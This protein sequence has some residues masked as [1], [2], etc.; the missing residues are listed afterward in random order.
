M[1]S[2]SSVSTLVELP[3][4]PHSDELNLDVLPAIYVL[5]TH[6]TQSGLH[7]VEERL[8]ARHAPLTYD[9]AEATIFIG[10]IG[11]KRRAEYELRCRKLWTEEVTNH[12][13][14]NLLAID[15]E[16]HSQKH[17]RK[18]RRIEVIEGYGNAESTA[19]SG[20]LPSEG[21]STES[22]PETEPAGA[23]SPAANPSQTSQVQVSSNKVAHASQLAGKAETSITEELAGAVHVIRLDWLNASLE[24][25]SLLPLKPYLVYSGK[26]V[27]RPENA[28][29]LE[30]NTSFSSAPSARFGTPQE[31][32]NILERAKADSG[33]TNTKYGK[34]MYSYTTTPHE[35]S[36][37]R[38]QTDSQPLTRPT[39]LLQETTSEHDRAVS[40]EGP[41][42]PAW[43]KEGKKYACQRS[44]R[45]NPPNKDFIKQLEKIKLARLLTHDQIGVRAYSTSIA[46]L[47]A[48]PY[49]LSNPREILALPGCDAKIAHLYQEWYH[50]EGHIKVVQEIED[51]PKL[52]VLRLFYEIWGVGATTARL[53]YNKGWRDLDDIVEHGW[54]TLSRVQQIG[55]KYYDQFLEKIP[56]KEV[57][58][59]SRK[60]VEHAR[61]IRDDGIECCI[62]GGY[63]R[64]KKESGDVDMIIS[65][66][67][68]SQTAGLITD[69][70]YSLEKEGWISHTL[71]L[72]LTTSNRGQ[73]TLPYRTSGDG[74]GFDSLD[75]ALVVWQD[76]D[77]PTKMEDLAANPKAKNPNIH[78]RV[79]I[80]ISPWRTVGCAI[81]GWSGGTIF[82]RDLRRYAK[83]VKGWKF[84]SSGIRDR[85]SGEVVDVEGVGGRSAT[86]EEAEKKVF[87]GLGLEY[88]EPWERC[89]G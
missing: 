63:R 36:Q 28:Q 24:L 88:R 71:T 85:A 20:G 84:D 3:G 62:V 79:D 58:F 46:A 43:V 51:D 42:M 30:D 57:Q 65:H 18:R 87:K 75:K 48:Y 6:L 49:T 22:E 1:E 77:W 83:N 13:S 27:A 56:R 66:R 39:H 52:Q 19:K 41:E 37:A 76:P 10:K 73:Q 38:S 82:Q 25:G 81:T 80:I 2:Q 9:V 47:A 17:P 78:R 45:A 54:H 67:D 23:S 70:V 8:L 55:V 5:P 68:E 40:G 60:V 26:K 59:I 53:F 50:N 35:N 7:E 61:R 33:L 21:S 4:S 34:S 14:G 12:A 64:G 44:S 15:E 11:T 74:G 72:N 32:G 31:K 69:I 86:M 29:S 16:S 89:T